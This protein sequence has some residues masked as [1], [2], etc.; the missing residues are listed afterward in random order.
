MSKTKLV[1]IPPY[2]L[3]NEELVN[4][5][6]FLPEWYVF[7]CITNLHNFNIGR[8][9]DYGFCGTLQRLHEYLDFP[10]KQITYDIC[11]IMQRLID[12][13]LIWA[14]FSNKNQLYT[15]GSYYYNYSSQNS[16][17]HPLKGVNTIDE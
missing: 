4:K 9:Y 14:N 1:T 12:E 10:E 7:N 8:G 6:L 3:D 13:K 11:I 16:D 15:F 17:L 2:L 5:N